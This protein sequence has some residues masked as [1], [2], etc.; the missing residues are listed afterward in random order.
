MVLYKACVGVKSRRSFERGS[1]LLRSGIEYPRPT[2]CR[3]GNADSAHRRVT[4]G[5]SVP[6]ALN[7]L[8]RHLIYRQYYC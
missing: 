8:A 5:V 1:H 6:L 2:A 4:V 7:L 3:R